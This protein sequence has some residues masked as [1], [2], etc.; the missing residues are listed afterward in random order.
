LNDYGQLG[1]GTTT[2]SSVPVQVRGVGGVGNLTGASSVTASGKFT[3]AYITA[4]QSVVCWGRNASGQLGNGS[5]DGADNAHTTP[6]AVVGVGG[7]GTLG[8]VTAITSGANHACA[9]LSSGGVD[10]WG[11]D[12]HG[13]L[14]N[15]GA[16]PG[17][18]SG[19]PV[20]VAGV[21][22]TGILAGATQISGGR[23]HVCALLSDHSVA[24][25]GRNENGE[26]GNGT[27]TTSSFPVH[28][29]NITTAT[30]VSAGEYHSCA[31]LADGTAQCWGAAAYGQIGDGTTADTSTPVTVIGP[32]GFGTLAGLANISAGGG[33]IT[34]TNDYEHTCALTTDGTVI[35]WGQNNYGQLGDGTTTMSIFPTG[36]ALL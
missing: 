9:L 17:T 1:N 25:W 5:I 21:G 31:L 8:N 30:Q 28:T 19:S 11:L 13:Q 33:D 15:G 3:C 4:S 34:E 29:L 27:T 12:D 20:Q 32:G 22:G 14:G 7:A 2:S 18:N 6:T 35:C 16:I 36:V 26:L 23:M 10:C 24:C